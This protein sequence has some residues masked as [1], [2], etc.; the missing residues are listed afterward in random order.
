MQDALLITHTDLKDIAGQFSDN[1]EARQVDPYIREAQ[2]GEFRRFLGD[3]LY[4]LVLDNY[5]DAGIYSSLMDGEDYTNKEGQ[6]VRFNGM[7]EVLKYWSCYRYI[8]SADILMMRFGNR[9]AED[10]IYSAGATREQ[11][12]NTVYNQ[13]AQALKFQH[14]AEA[15]IETNI[16]DYPTYRT[17]KRK[18]EKQSFEIDKLPNKRYDRYHYNKYYY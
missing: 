15:Y 6:A 5:P 10:G 4:L 18:P 11:V 2:T 7:S 1:I 14:D 16:D 17:N 12:K 8:R 13:K 3:E 9:I